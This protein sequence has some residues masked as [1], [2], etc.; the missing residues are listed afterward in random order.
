[1]YSAECGSLLC[2][3]AVAVGYTSDTATAWLL[4]NVAQQALNNT[5][6]QRRRSVFTIGGQKSEARRAEVRVEFLG[7]GSGSGGAL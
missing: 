4:V 2:C 5:H 6:F 3:S 1:M 7:R